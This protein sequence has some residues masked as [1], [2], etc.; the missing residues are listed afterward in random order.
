VAFADRLAGRPIRVA[1]AI[2]PSSR[3]VV[4]E[5]D[6]PDQ[7]TPKPLGRRVAA[8]RALGQ[9]PRYLVILFAA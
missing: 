7:P 4:P 1:E 9:A 3:L 8:V 6:R 2:E 5:R